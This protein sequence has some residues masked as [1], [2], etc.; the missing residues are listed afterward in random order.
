MALQEEIWQF[1]S[2]QRKNILHTFLSLKFFLVFEILKVL[3]GIDSSNLYI[4][5][6]V[7]CP[8]H[9]LVV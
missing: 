6:L 4:A 3:K 8:S 7:S 5:S 1:T 2:S 9:K